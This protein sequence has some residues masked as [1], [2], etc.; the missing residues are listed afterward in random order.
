[1]TKKC[2]MPWFTSSLKNS[3]RLLQLL[4]A[5]RNLEMWVPLYVC[6][7]ILNLTDKMFVQFQLEAELLFSSF[8]NSSIVLELTFIKSSI[9]F[10]NSLACLQ[11]NQGTA[12]EG[13]LV[14][15]D[16]LRMCLLFFPS[17]IWRPSLMKRCKPAKTSRPLLQA[18]SPLNLR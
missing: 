5:Y 3:T 12:Q 14:L 1:M 4:K 13:V 9:Q 6:S 2:R 16:Y 17:T 10:M 11:S 7:L 15:V 8:W 18:F